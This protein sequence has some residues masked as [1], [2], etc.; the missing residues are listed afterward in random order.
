M[1]QEYNELA[2]VGGLTVGTSYGTAN[3][4]QEIQDI[5]PTH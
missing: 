4:V 1:R 5:K 3:L 2:K